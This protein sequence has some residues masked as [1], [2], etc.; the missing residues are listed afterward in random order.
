MLMT[1][2]AQAH[3]A[4]R[5]SLRGW[6]RTLFLL[7]G[8]LV[9]LAG[10]V[11]STFSDPLTLLSPL[12]SVGFALTALGLLLMRLTLDVLRHLLPAW[13]AKAD[14]WTATAT[15]HPRLVP[16]A[17]W[18]C[19]GVGALVFALLAIVPDTIGGWIGPSSHSGPFALLVVVVCIDVPLLIACAPLFLLY[20]VDRPR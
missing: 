1:T 11:T 9:F 15:R 10:I 20:R 3:H 2:S 5:F 18:W 13:Q 8:L 17:Q 19:A 14:T 4:P 6:V 12:T 7:P 16:L